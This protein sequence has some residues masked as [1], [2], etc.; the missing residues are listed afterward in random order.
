VLINWFTV[1]AQMVNF[2]ILLWLLQRFLYQPILDAMQKREKRI[3]ARM[4]EAETARQAAGRQQEALAAERQDFENQKETMQREARREIE[5]WHTAE[6]E[7]IRQEM[8]GLRQSR[9]ES[10]QQ[11]QER[12]QKDL[13]IRITRQFLKLARKALSDLADERIE[14]QLIRIFV[15]KL[16]DAVADA[17]PA[18][19]ETAHVFHVSS[20]F[21]LQDDVKAELENLLQQQFTEI[22]DIDYD[23]ESDLGFGIRLLSGDWKVEW[24]LAWYLRELEQMLLPAMVKGEKT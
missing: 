5:Q 10:L 1:L 20:G 24:N 21:K 3:S 23:T 7:K 11:E 16:K 8:E 2:L 14:D 4:E 6:M 18:L 22:E 13:K 17:D 9:L 15:R 12:F 19:R